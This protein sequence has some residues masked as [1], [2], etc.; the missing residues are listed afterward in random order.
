MNDSLFTAPGKKR[1]NQH[2]LS[3]CEVLDVVP[4][5]G[6]HHSFTSPNNCGI[7]T[8]CIYYAESK[9]SFHK[10]FVRHHSPENKEARTKSQLGM[11]KNL[12]DFTANEFHS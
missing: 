9:D 6:K 3:R 11:T 8:P 2:L 1:S 10:K 4:E 12:L 7:M 5:F